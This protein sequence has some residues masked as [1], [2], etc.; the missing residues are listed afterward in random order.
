[1]LA[2]QGDTFR[3]FL[4]VGCFSPA[5]QKTTHKKESTMLPQANNVIWQHSRQSKT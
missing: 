2:H 4:L 5:G 3:L 1:M